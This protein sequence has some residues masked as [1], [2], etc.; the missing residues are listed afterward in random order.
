MN[1]RLKVLFVC[2]M[3]KQRSVTAEC[4]YRNDPR[5]EVRSAGVREGAARRV[6]EADLKWADVVF[7]MERD[8]KQWIAERFR[9]T[10]LPPIDVLDIPDD[11][12]VMEPQLQEIMRSLLDPELD[13]LVRT[14]KPQP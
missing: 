13:H 12:D 9:E 6:S 5:L 1:T 14:K 10:D 11:F 4:L 2:A 3:N 8:Q 7:V